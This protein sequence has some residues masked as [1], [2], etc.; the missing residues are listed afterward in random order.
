MTRGRPPALDRHLPQKLRRRDDNDLPESPRRME[1]PLVPSC[2]RLRLGRYSTLEN[3]FVAGIGRGALRS[4][5]WK[6]QGSC[7][8]KGGCLIDILVARVF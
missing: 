3:H 6:N 2:Y 5:S 1:V 4:L 7:L 8:R